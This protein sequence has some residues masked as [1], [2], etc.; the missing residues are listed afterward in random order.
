MT[1][2]PASESCIF[3]RIVK[4]ELPGVRVYEDTDILVFLDINPVAPGHSLVITK[5]HYP[6]LLDMPGHLG[7]PV[8]AALGKVGRAVMAAT[9]AEGF[10]CL[11]NNFAASGQMVFHTHWHVIPR[12]EGDGLTHWP[13]RPYADA[14]SM[15]SVAAAIGLHI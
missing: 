7:G 10:N 9:G 6:T 13:H 14:A 12:F 11:Q 1:E 4:D 8:I 5:G 2:T 3:C 15:Q